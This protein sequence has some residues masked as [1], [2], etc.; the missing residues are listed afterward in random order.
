MSP[1]FRGMLGKVMRVLVSPLG[2]FSA[3]TGG[4]VSSAIQLPMGCTVEVE[5]EFGF[6]GPVV[7]VLD[8]D[9][10]RACGLVEGGG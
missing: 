3:R 10:V 8:G 7:E 1:G 2:W 4:R 5:G 9:V 6:A